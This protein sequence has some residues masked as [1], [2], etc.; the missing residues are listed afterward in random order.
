MKAKTKNLSFPI[1]RQLEK[2]I[3][4][5]VKAMKLSKADVARQ[6]LRK[7]LGI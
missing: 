6:L 2:A 3:E 5:M 4:S 7:A 1:D